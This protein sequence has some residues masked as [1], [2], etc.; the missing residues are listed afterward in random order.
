MGRSRGGQPG[1]KNAL[2]HGFY[3]TGFQ[4]AECDDLEAMIDGGLTNEIAMLRV[5]ARRLMER[6]SDA[7]DIEAMVA[8]LDALG[9]TATKISG[10]SNFSTL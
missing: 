7:G 6:A 9:S 1:N 10:N 4:P 2:K 5:L 3:S 8:V